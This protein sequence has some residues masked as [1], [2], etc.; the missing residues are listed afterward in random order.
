MRD[1]P[2]PEMLLELLHSGR[3]AEVAWSM[4][5]QI[6]LDIAGL[7]PEDAVICVFERHAAHIGTGKVHLQARSL[8]HWF[9]CQAV[10]A[11]VLRWYSPWLCQDR[12]GLI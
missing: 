8:P 6:G 12:E 2:E 11:G 4:R 7:K 10:D 3:L 1:Y 5:S 9:C